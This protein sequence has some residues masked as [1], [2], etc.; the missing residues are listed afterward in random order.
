MENLKKLLNNN[1]WTKIFVLIKSKKIDP[2]TEI[3]GGNTIIHMAATNNNSEIIK[4]FLNFDKDI[5][6]KSNEDGDTPIHLL[7][8][9][10]YTDLLK[11]CIIKYPE[12]LNLLNNN[13]ENIPTILFDDLDFIKFI[14]EKTKLNT[15]N[16]I[17]D[18]VNGENII[19]K[20]II[21]NKEKDKHYKIIKLLLKNQKNYIANQKSLLCDSI[22]ENKSYL[23]DLLLKSGYDV[24]KQDSAY[25]T[26][27][28]YA[29]KNKDYKLID[30][31]I[32]LD[33]DINYSGPEGDYNPMIYAIDNNDERMINL[34]LS[35][36]FN[37]KNHNRYLETPLHHIL[38]ETSKKIN[39]QP[40]TMAAL[41]FHSDLNAKNVNG[42]TPLHLLCRN[43]D[44]KNYRQIIG[45]K[46]LDIFIE[47]N[48]NKRPIDYLKG[49]HL[50]DFIDIVV[51]SY[52]RLIEGKINHIDKCT[53]MKKK[54]KDACKNE[55]KKYIFKTK[56][57]IPVVE[58]HLIMN[59]RIKIITGN[60]S[61]H[62]L[63]NSDILHNVIYTI[64]MLKKYKNIGV[65]FQYNFKDKMITDKSMM[66]NS[67]MYKYPGELIISNLIKIYTENFYELSPYLIVWKGPNQYYINPT[68]KI[69][70]KKLLYNKQ[71]RFVVLKL[72]LVT[73]SGTHANILI[74]DKIKNTFERFE[75]Y[76]VVPYVDSDKL[77]MFLESWS[78]KTFNSKYL[79]P[80]DIF[81]NVGNLGP[82]VISN[83]SQQNVQKLGDP[84]GYCLAWTFWYLEMRIN[85]PDTLPADLL[86][87][88]MKS[89]IDKKGQI[90]SSQLF[91]SFIRDYASDLDR[92]KNNFMINAGVKKNN[93]YNLVLSPDDHKKVLNK[94]AFE[95]KLLIN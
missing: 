93:I 72:T 2:Y 30:M 60:K 39:L 55:L 45:N 68:L 43:F 49:D 51:D 63:F 36:N 32:K 9:H 79:S 91:I 95:F 29:V 35:H 4:Y 1:K 47:N 81:K 56:R 70:L 46:K 20:N 13:N 24:N 71:I 53:N 58:D 52:T 87:N 15:I 7:A 8:S 83:D 12:F 84:S 38:N 69:Y 89:I 94:L 50:Y 86:Y 77:D 33:A 57:S 37:L 42:E 18:D 44:W 6:M 40:S 19:T 59:N 54:E 5:L 64:A 67:D 22:K 61:L 88:S 92:L 76:G 17:I 26:P 34:L 16:I 11:D 31:L 82:Q 27:F 75:P 73:G 28:L 62:G 10:G 48:K 23:I 65:P 85:N 21:K 3:N 66:E 80:K 90:D 41:I 74:Y 14:S 25:L 78:K